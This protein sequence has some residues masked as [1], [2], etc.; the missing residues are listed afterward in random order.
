MSH[1]SAKLDCFKQR[2]TRHLL[3]LKR[4]FC[5]QKSN[6]RDQSDFSFAA[7]IVS[8]FACVYIFWL[9]YHSRTLFSPNNIIVSCFSVFFLLIFFLFLRYL[10]TFWGLRSGLRCAKRAASNPKVNFRSTPC[11]SC[12]QLKINNEVCVDACRAYNN[13]Q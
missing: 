8:Y 13:S 1:L 2:N 7:L 3:S 11:L 4:P 12:T 9:L 6:F 5:K 10:T